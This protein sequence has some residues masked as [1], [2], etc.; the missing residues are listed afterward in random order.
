MKLSIFFFLQSVSG[1]FLP[2][3]RDFLHKPWS[4][5]EE[6]FL[7][8][9]MN[10]RSN[11]LYIS[12]TDKYINSI[13][14]NFDC[15]PSDSNFDPLDP[16]EFDSVFE[17]E[18]FEKKNELE[19]LLEDIFNNS[20]NEKYIKK[21]KDKVENMKSSNFEV[22]FNNELNFSNVAGYDN[23]KKEL[24]Q[25]SDILINPDKYS[26]YNVRVPK[27][28]LLEGPPGNG[29]TLIARALSGQINV[30]FVYGGGSIFQEK[31]VGVGS[32]R[33]RELF[34]L[35]DRAKPCIVFLDEI[36]A[37]G[38]TRGSS[39]E[40]ADR[41]RDTTLNQLLTLMDGF[42]KTDGIFL[43]FATNRADLLDPALLRPGRIDKKIYIGNPDF[44]TRS[45]LI[46]LYL[47]GK[48][49]DYSISES[50]INSL[51]NGWSGAQIENLLNEAMLLAIRENRGRIK[52]DDIDQIFTRTIVGLSETEFS[53]SE[54]MLLRI[55]IHELGHALSSLMLVNHP[56]LQSININLHSHHA[57]GYTI[58]DRNETDSTI[59]TNDRLFSS[60]IVLLSGRTA[61]KIHFN[62]SVTTGASK[63]FQEAYKL[64]E[65]MIIH[66]G[67]G[68][69]S[70]YP[71]IS[72]KFR[73]TID[74]QI[75]SLLQ[76]AENESYL[77]LNKFKDSMIFLAP[78]LIEKKKLQYDEIQNLINI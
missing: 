35:A 48:P 63:D 27:G 8:T 70:I 24:L 75:Y 25:C 52:I 3:T 47:K 28:L 42:I 4:Y 43:I 66:Y 65:S 13:V 54:N 20:K 64:A 60:L 11:L 1:F 41:E 31:Y 56:K 46:N 10:R 38:R 33:L 61:E 62:N 5:K 30:P 23:V 40:N 53:F 37:I 14:K 67:M 2:K 55:S 78:I 17:E 72:E 6:G 26:A 15:I 71:Q 50:M 77:I 57:P 49:H 59:M 39:N 19:S 45:E 7:L 32:A 73:S 51:T 12:E 29:K 34:E 68:D 22:T 58:F 16:E 9:K 69:K 44:K 21:I 18:I 74:D 36:D 76:S